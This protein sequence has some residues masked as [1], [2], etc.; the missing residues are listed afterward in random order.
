MSKLL[1]SYMRKMFRSKIFWFGAAFC[2]IYNVIQAV[3]ASLNDDGTFAVNAT[4]SLMF[5]PMVIAGVAGLL[6]SPEFTNGTVR[7]KLMI[8]HSKQN[9]YL[10]TLI[11]DTVMTI[12]YYACTM[13]PMFIT[14]AALGLTDGF[15]AKNI[16]AVLILI[17]LLTLSSTMATLFVSMNIHDSKSTALA[18]MLQYAGM[19]FY[20][21][22]MIGV[23]EG[24]FSETVSDILRFIS[25]FIPQGQ[26]DTL[27][28]L[29]M[30]DKPW[31]TAICTVS[32]GTAFAILGLH[33]FK[34]SDLK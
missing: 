19:I 26:V 4:I 32:L 8:G 11:C 16:A 10:A 28:L 24:E 3:F 7:N 1:N 15:K 34:K 17:F 33:L 29:T 31:L 6:T 25:R 5:N 14:G 13:I 30:P 20:V 2:I 27:N 18:I 12:V 23:T 22:A 21:S 9:I